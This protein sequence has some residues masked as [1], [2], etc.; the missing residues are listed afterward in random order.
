MIDITET[1]PPPTGRT[2][3]LTDVSAGFLVWML[4]ASGHAGTFEGYLGMSGYHVACEWSDLKSLV[5]E[6]D[7][8]REAFDYAFCQTR[9][10]GD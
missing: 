2:F 5:T 4:A 1:T 10:Y 7:Q 6:D 8:L 3:T 9:R